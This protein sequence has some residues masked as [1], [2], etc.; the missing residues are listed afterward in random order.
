MGVINEIREKAKSKL[1]TI[2]L[3]EF[4]DERILEAASIIEKEKIANVIL[5]TKDKIDA[6]DNERYVQEFYELR[7]AKGI[8]VEQVRKIFEDPLYHAAMLVREGKV[9]GYVAGAARTSAEVARS[10]IYCLGIDKRI[11]IASS[12]FIMVVPNCPYGENGTFL[13][14]DCGVIPEPNARQLACISIAT[15]ELAQKVLNLTPRVALLSYST[16]GSAEGRAIGK[17]EEALNLLKEMAPDLVVDGEFQVDTAIVPEVA[18]IKYPDS[19]VGGKA[20]ILIFPNL[21]AGNIGYKLTQRMADARA[22]GPLL[23][24]LNKPCSDLSRGCSVDDIVDC[25]AVTAIRAQ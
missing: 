24:G 9:D 16:K 2:V 19:P 20:N 4:E 13:F 25:V 17:V 18:R 7:K 15:A 8:S 12:S 11:N 23:M 22:I 3:P 10:A 14:A 1:K 21:E 6:G 5:L